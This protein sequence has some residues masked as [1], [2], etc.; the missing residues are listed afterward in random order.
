MSKTQ[1]LSPVSPQKIRQT[2][3]FHPH[4]QFS[5]TSVNRDASSMFRQS[6][7]STLVNLPSS[8]ILL[9]EC[10]L[11]DLLLPRLS[12]DMALTQSFSPGPLRLPPEWCSNVQT[13]LLIHCLH[14]SLPGIIIKY[15]YGL[16]SCYSRLF[17]SSWYF[18]NKVYIKNQAILRKKGIGSEI[19]PLS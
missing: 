7:V 15:K 14:S 3:H 11:W 10:C 6:Y 5:S 17:P 2:H 16:L 19:K 9:P 13:L 12:T 8:P 4:L 18:L 1:L